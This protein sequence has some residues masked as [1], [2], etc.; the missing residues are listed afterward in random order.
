MADNTMAVGGVNSSTSNQSVVN[1]KDFSRIRSNEQSESQTLTP[2]TTDGEEQSLFAPGT[3][4]E[5][6]VRPIVEAVNDY[7]KQ[8]NCNLELSYN[9][10]ANLINVKITDKETGEVLREFPSE[11]MIDRMVKAEKTAEGNQMRG[12]FVNRTI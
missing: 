8:N 11:E 12:I 6:N 3:A 2:A 1:D 5:E 7:M 4:T 9:K 10:E